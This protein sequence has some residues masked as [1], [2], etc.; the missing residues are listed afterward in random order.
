MSN[1]TVLKA[2]ELLREGGLVEVVEE[3]KITLQ[4]QA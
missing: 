2:I 3:H 1:K 4:E